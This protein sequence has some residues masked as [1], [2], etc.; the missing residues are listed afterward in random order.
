MPAEATQGDEEGGGAAARAS[1]TGTATAS[2]TASAT[3]NLEIEREDFQKLQLCAARVVACEPVPKTDKLLKLTLDIGDQQRTVV[4][5]IAGPYRPE[6][7][8]GRTVVY[9]ANLKPAKIRGVVSQGMILAAG[10][11]EVLA[12]CGLDREVPP[13]TRIR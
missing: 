11:A 12:L 1:A 8:V 3:A 13:G 5:G 9:L 4:S 2:A 7:L 10:E 6:E